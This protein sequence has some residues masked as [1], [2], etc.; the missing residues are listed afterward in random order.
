[1]KAENILQQ[2]FTKSAVIFKTST[3]DILLPQQNGTTYSG[4]V[5][6]VAAVPVVS[7]VIIV[8]IC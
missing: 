2:A 7:T 6:T 3:S 8:I 4:A 5:C 1:M